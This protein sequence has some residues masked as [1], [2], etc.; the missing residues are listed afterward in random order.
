MIQNAIFFL[1]ELPD[2]HECGGM[3][4]Y[5]LYATKF[6]RDFE[7]DIG[8]ISYVIRT[9]PVTRMSLYSILTISEGTIYLV[10]LRRVFYFYL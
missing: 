4:T 9:L 5:I 10:V 2:I 8:L 1:T 6:G 3:T 7:E